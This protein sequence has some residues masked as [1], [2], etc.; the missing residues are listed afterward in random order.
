MSFFSLYIRLRLAGICHGSTTTTAVTSKHGVVAQASFDPP[1]LTV[2]VKQDRA[3]EALL[4]T[5]A[6]FVV[7]IMAEGAEKVCTFCADPVDSNIL[8]CDSLVRTVKQIGHPKNLGKDLK[9]LLLWNLQA[10]LLQECK[11]KY[12]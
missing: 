10:E 11:K 2:A 4:L 1:G 8:L 6:K 12:R 3:A 7:N 9:S 5:G